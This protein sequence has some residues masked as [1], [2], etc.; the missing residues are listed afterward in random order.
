M[1]DASNDENELDE[2]V[3]DRPHCR[4]CGHELPYIAKYCQRCGE[5]LY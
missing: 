2:K 4:F 1:N 5:E 3:T